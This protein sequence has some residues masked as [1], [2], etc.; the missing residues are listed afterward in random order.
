MGTLQFRKITKSLEDISFDCG[1]ESINDYV[2][3]SYYPVLTQHAYTFSIMNG[4][5]VLGYFQILFREIELEDFPEEISEYDPEIKRTISAIHIRYIAID[6][7]YQRKGIGTATLQAIIKNVERLAELWP[8][9]V[10][11]LDAM[12]HLA[13]WYMQVGF[14]KMKTNTPGQNGVSDAMYFDC[15]KHADELAEFVE[16]TVY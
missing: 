6:K 4:D 11:T 2:R 9:R 16:S 7:K 14:V 8:I 1:V 12:V 15:M 3:E 5:I 13:P 10:I